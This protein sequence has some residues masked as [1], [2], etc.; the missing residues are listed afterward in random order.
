TWQ[1]I[2]SNSTEDNLRPIVP[3]NHPGQTFVLWMRGSYE[4]YKKY[5]TSI[6]L[7]TGAKIRTST[8]VNCQR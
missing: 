3:A 2:T 6:V 8:K 4:T 7:R 1:P 5:N